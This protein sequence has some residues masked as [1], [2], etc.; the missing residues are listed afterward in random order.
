MP[1]LY[2]TLATLC[3]SLSTIVGGFFSKRNDGIKG[4]SSLYTFLVT[5]SAFIFWLIVF[6]FDRTFNPEVIIYSLLFG[7]FFATFHLSYMLAIKNGPIV[8]TG[9]FS[10]L[11]LIGTTIWGFFFWDTK[12]S[13]ITILG[14]VIVCVAIFLCL[15]KGKTNDEKSKSFSFKWLIFAILA[16][17]GNA[18]CAIVQKTEQINFGGKYGNFFMLIAIAFSVLACFILWLKDKKEKT[19]TVIKTS[20]HIPVIAGLSNAVSNLFI[21]ILAT[22]T[23]S[24]SLIYPVIGV[25]GLMLVTLASKF[26]FKE[27][28]CWWQWLGIALGTISVA[29][30]SI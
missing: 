17:A 4:S 6:L 30:L 14:L 5:C 9:L 2:L 24:P 19:K 20:L 12:P 25:G 7:T 26:I 29:L 11:S 28:L 18:G 10:Q 22:T 3:I 27:Q 13:L 8:L 15:Y 23:L 21:I 1:Y 16:F